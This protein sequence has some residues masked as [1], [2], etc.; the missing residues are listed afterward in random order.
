[1]S[2]REPT[3]KQ[4]IAFTVILSF[5]ASIFG[6]ILTLGVISPTLGFADSDGGP[7]TFN[8]PTLLEKITET[9][10]QK[11]TVERVIGQDEAIVK[12]VESASPA[13]VSIVAT[14]DVAVIEQY[15]IDP[16]G[17]SGFQIPQYRERGTEKR[18]V[19]SG[20]GFLVSKD[21]LIMTNKHVVSDSAA[22]FTAFFNDGSKR[23][24]KILARDPLHD[25][26]ILKVEGTD[27]PSLEL[28]DSPGVKIGQ[29][30][31]A[32]GNALGEFRNTVSAGV[33]SGLERSVVAGG[34]MNTET[35]QELIQ[36]DAAINPGNSGGPLLDIHGKV[37]GINTAVA[38][39]AENI[40]FAIPINKAK[41]ALASVQKS[42][43]IIYP[44]LGVRYTL[45][46]KDRAE[47]EKLPKDYGVLI[48]DGPA[49]E[50]A[51]V[52]GSP[53]EKAGLKKGDIILEI[54]G[55]RIDQSHSLASV[56]QKYGVGD[57]ISLKLFRDG[58][59]IELKATLAE[60]KE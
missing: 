28:G 6:T 19:S 57:T 2:D 46:T 10:T 58:K 45:I 43:K 48:A 40:G 16:F 26:A 27:Y 41:T 39:G 53:A 42:G 1:M 11:E 37:I 22:E 24:A 25:L 30:V 60:R 7:I 34:G 59:E 36:T 15:F 32:I 33:V 51:I 50:T 14:K 13:V 31:I 49:G 20:T 35:L 54:Q 23:V 55:E 9:I 38:A 3:T 4:L 56:I 18:E 52:P 21:G 17:N 12:V 29:T 5:I 8:K 47:E 44:F